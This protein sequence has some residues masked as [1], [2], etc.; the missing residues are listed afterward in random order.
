[1]TTEYG[2]RA[3]FYF[4]GRVESSVRVARFRFE[5][6]VNIPNSNDDAHVQHSNSVHRAV[7]SSHQA[8]DWQD[9]V[10]LGSLGAENNSKLHIAKELSDCQCLRMGISM[11][12]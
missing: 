4:F 11:S 12:A 8:S 9:E 6:E 3:Q 7:A 2:A 5:S 1:M 10:D